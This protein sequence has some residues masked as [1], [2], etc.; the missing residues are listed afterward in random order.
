VYYRQYCLSCHGADGRGVE[1]RASMPNLPD[2]TNRSWQES[3]SNPQLLVGILDGKGTLMPPFRGRV[4]EEDS[5]ALTAYIRAF[6]PSP[7]SPPSAEAAS[8]FEERFRR[9]QDEWDALQKQLDELA[10][11]PPKD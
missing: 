8:D 6:A 11:K 7:S 9:L 2:F 4:S 10:K 1:L 5:R 3:H